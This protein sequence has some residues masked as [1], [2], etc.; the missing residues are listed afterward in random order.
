MTSKVL[1]LFGISTK[2]D[3]AEWEG[4]VA[5][6]HCP[7]LKKK[8]VKTRK[9]QP[10]ISIGTCSVNYGVKDS[11]GVIICP[12]RFPERNQ[13][14][15]DCLHLLTLHEPG[16]ELHKIP[17]VSIPG[18]NVD[19][20]VASVRNGKVVDFVG[21]EIQALDTTGTVWPERQR[22]LRS[23]GFSNVEGADSRSSFGMN[24]KMTAKTTLVQLHHKVETFEQLNR[25]LVL[26]LQDGLLEY[27]GREFNFSGV[28]DAKIGNAM[29]FHSYSL[30]GDD[31]NLR[32]ALNS[33]VSTDSQGIAACLGLQVSASVELEV[34]IAALQARIS[35]RTLLSV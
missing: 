4:I 29:H 13:V 18:G 23:A 7:Y 1:E 31:D 19:Y 6:Q 14:F 26:V 34:I 30:K 16:N 28:E 11:K 8:C 17:E 27:M 2:S 21:I 32:L 24:W 3:D 10:E 25:H 20:V 15:M 33:R 12:H 35:G 9:S 22:F 5:E